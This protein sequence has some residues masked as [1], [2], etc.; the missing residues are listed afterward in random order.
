MTE[1]IREQRIERIAPFTCNF[2]RRHID[3]AEN[4][5]L[6]IQKINQALQAERNRLVEEIEQMKG[7]SDSPEP[8]EAEQGYNQAIDTIIN[9]I[10]NK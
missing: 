2:I 3:N 9:L 5:E 4:A 1:E 8:I 7:Y 10:N 6:I